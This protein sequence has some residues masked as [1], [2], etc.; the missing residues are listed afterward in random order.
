[1]SISVAN[2]YQ[3]KKNSY[4]QVIFFISPLRGSQSVRYIRN[5]IITEISEISI[6]CAVILKIYI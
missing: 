3:F 5:I 1:M 2:L 4:K 6:G